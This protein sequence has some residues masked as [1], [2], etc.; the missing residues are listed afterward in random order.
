MAKVE[1][2]GKAQGASPPNEPA[3]T[4]SDLLEALTIF[5][6]V[7]D[8][9]FDKIRQELRP[10][11]AEEIAIENARI[12]GD[13]MA[14]NLSA[15]SIGKVD[16]GKQIKPV[17]PIEEI[18]GLGTPQQDAIAWLQML[19]ASLNREH[20]RIVKKNS[21]EIGDTLIGE[22]LFIAKVTLAIKE[23]FQAYQ[24]EIERLQNGK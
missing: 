2:D 4:R 18:K 20:D 23:T 16:F 5:A 12:R 6:K 10:K 9:K 19:C 21:V 13:T 3:L 22:Q 11:S 17:E 1:S 14:T 24:S 15:A 8:E 7:Q